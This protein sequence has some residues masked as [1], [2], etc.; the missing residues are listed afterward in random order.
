MKW[1]NTRRH[2]LQDRIDAENTKYTKEHLELV[3]TPSKN[4]K[5]ECDSESEIEI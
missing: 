5:S 3:S 2:K 4:S 1:E